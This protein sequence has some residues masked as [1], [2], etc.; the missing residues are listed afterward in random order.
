[1]ESITFA[2]LHLI[3]AA[4]SVSPHG[5]RGGSPFLSRT[6][7]SPSRFPSPVFAVAL[8]HRPAR[9]AITSN[10][11]PVSFSPPFLSNLFVFRERRYK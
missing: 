10:S 1:M 2:D 11:A 9:A 7:F 4:A 6:F 5:A 8:R 3:A